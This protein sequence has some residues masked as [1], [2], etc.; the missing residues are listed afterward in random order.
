MISAAAGTSPDLTI[1]LTDRSGVFYP[2]VQ[3]VEDRPPTPADSA[4]HEKFLRLKRILVHFRS[5]GKGALAKYRG[6]IEHERVLGTRSGP[7]ILDRLL[8]DGILT[9]DGSFYFLDPAN[10]DKHLGISWDSLKKGRTSKKLL[11]YLSAIG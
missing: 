6:K 7:A 3:F 2:A 9:R 10:I 4:L 11:Q 8:I 5:H 1:A